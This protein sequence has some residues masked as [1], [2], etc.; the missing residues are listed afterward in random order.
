[1]SKVTKA[2]LVA[3]A[4]FTSMPVL[5]RDNKPKGEV[6]NPRALADVQSYCINKIELS[7][8]DRHIVEDF[9]KSESKP[10][11]LLTKLPW[12][13][14]ESCRN[15]NPDATA[16]LEFVSLNVTR[17]GN[18]SLP[19]I[20]P[21]QDPDA[22]IKVVLT[23]G[24]TSA[25]TLLYRTQA[26]SLES[27]ADRGANPHEDEKPEGPAERRDAVYHVF[28]SLINDLQSVRASRSK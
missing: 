28:W 11:H 2:T 14:V 12:K 26:T 25:E 22:P 24:D 18:Q 7:N 1:M 6:P 17:V 15:G 3:C 20:T 21:A 5:S 13:L 8:W 16:T 9:V 4:L 23:V 27:N 19:P 10:K